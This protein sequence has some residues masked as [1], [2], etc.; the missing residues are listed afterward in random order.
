[1]ELHSGVH[2]TDNSHNI[3]FYNEDTARPA[4]AI[5]CVPDMFVSHG[6]RSDILQYLKKIQLKTYSI[7]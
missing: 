6:H 4:N 2:M 5:F 1:M 7:M 3:W